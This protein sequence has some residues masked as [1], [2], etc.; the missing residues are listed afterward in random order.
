MKTR[1][2]IILMIVAVVASSA[3]TYMVIPVKHTGGSLYSPWLLDNMDAAQKLRDSFI[4]IIGVDVDEK[5]AVLTIYMTDENS[6]KYVQEIDDL[7]DVPFDILS[8][9]QSRELQCLKTY[10]SIR[11]IPRTHNAVTDELHIIKHQKYLVNQYVDLKCPDFSDL[12]SMKKNLKKYSL[13]IIPQRASVEGGQRL[14]PQEITV[15][16][17]INNTVTWMNEDDVIHT[18]G[19]DD[20]N[21]S[22]FTGL[23][24]PGE[25]SSVTFNNTGIFNY[26]GIPG[27]W[28]TGKVIVLDE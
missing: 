23:M 22:W 11:E 4:P 12:E 9:T 20:K 13:V 25:S 28:A 27:P 19:S 26:H 6:E 3:I 15:V 18:F 17:G 2:L 21:N 7:L 16:L 5:I 8:E 14:N 24:N 10:K 1:L